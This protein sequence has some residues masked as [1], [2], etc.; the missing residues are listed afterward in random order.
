MRWTM[1]MLIKLVANMVLHAID[2][3]QIGE[4]QNI[5]AAIPTIPDE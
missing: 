4:Y 2:K 1:E 5:A 3:L